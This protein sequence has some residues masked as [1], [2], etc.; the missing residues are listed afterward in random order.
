VSE[1]ATVHRIDPARNVVVEEVWVRET[2]HLNGAT[3]SRDGLV[4]ATDGGLVTID[5]SSGGW[6]H[7]QLPGA[8]HVVRDDDGLWVAG[9]STV[10]LRQRGHEP[11]KVA[12]LGG[13]ISTLLGGAGRVLAVTEDAGETT[14]G[15][16]L[17]S[18]TR[19][20]RNLLVDDRWARQRPPS[21]TGLLW[22]QLRVQQPVRP[23][24]RLVAVDMRSASL[25]DWGP[26]R[27][28][29]R[30]WSGQHLYGLVEEPGGERNR[31]VRFAPA[32]GAL[33]EL[34]VGC[35]SWSMAVA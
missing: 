35:Y 12:D 30:A 14:T 5:P 9:G 22:L 13:W 32:S 11:V 25:I 20:P 18:R 3:L 26:H 29:P 8:R 2:G 6:T 28:V 23:G 7:E 10:Y 17:L 21:P 15:V 34:A 24:R 31:L 19:V 4:V 16:W 27:F 33:T 1:H